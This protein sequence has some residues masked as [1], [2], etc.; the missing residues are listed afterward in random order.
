MGTRSKW[1]WCFVTWVKIPTVN[2][3]NGVNSRAKIVNSI[4]ELNL[5]RDSQMQI[6]FDFTKVSHNTAV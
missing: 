3:T 5:E 4:K 6:D 1:Q 2:I